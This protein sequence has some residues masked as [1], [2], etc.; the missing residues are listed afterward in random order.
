MKTFDL[1]RNALRLYE[2]MG[3]FSSLNRTDAGY[4]EFSS[5]NFEELNFIVRAKDVGFSLN[6]I[7]ALLE[8]SRV[9]DAMTCGDVAA[10]TEKKIEEI[11]LEIKLLNS[12]KAFLAEFLTTCTN[13]KP[14]SNCSVVKVGFEKSA[15]CPT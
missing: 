5:Q 9:S 11:E 14:D 2:E 8:M 4:R 3:L 13:T 10:E 12:K 7:K 6:E 15:C 1:G